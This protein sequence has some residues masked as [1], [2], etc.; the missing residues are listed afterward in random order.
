MAIL[1]IYWPD[2]YSIHSAYWS[3]SI[4]TLIIPGQIVLLPQPLY[5][6]Y[7]Q[8]LFPYHFIVNV[9]YKLHAIIKVF[10]FLPDAAPEGN[11]G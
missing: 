7:Q 10:V 2:K 8:T 6:L 11:G 4:L 9:Y 3:D 1:F 5:P